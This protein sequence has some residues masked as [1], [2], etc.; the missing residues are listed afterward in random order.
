MLILYNFGE[1]VVLIKKGERIAQGIFMKY[2]T[3]DNSETTSKRLGG[4][5][6]TGN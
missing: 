4:F 2:L 3:V 5:G 6:S 1:E